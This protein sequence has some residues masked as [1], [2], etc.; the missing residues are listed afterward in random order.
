MSLP[1]A[2]SVLSNV[3]PG[4]AD[5]LSHSMLAVVGVLVSCTLIVYIH[6]RKLKKGA[7]TATA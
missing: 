7:S 6:Y 1:L 3:P 2:G 5:T 4:T